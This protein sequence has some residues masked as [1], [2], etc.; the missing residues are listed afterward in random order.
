MFREFDTNKIVH[1]SGKVSDLRGEVKKGM[2]FLAPIA[3]GTGIKTKILEAMAMEMPVV[4]NS[5]GAE[6]IPGVNGKHWCASEQPQYT[7]FIRIIYG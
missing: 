3:Y 1:F 6:G 5:V 7:F 2:V 4:T